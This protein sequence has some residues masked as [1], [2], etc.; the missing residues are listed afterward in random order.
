MSPRSA[1]SRQM[2]LQG[3]RDH[4]SLLSGFFA[5][6]SLGCDTSQCGS[7]ACRSDGSGRPRAASPRGIDEHNRS[8]S[9]A[10]CGR[11]RAAYRRRAVFRLPRRGLAGNGRALAK[12]AVVGCSPCGE[13]ATNSGLSS[14]DNEPGLERRTSLPFAT[15]E[16]SDP[17]RGDDGERRRLGRASFI[18]LQ[19]TNCK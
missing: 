13:N 8:N 16:L 10:P 6:P 11:A 3:C 4:L 15:Q 12:E 1:F 9:C 14:A 5:H 17:H 19:R 2:H 7:S 18:T